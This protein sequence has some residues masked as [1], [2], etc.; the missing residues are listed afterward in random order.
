MG[1][2]HRQV[3][4]PAARAVPARGGDALRQ[5]IDSMSNEE[6][7]RLLRAPAGELRERLPGDN[8]RAREIERAVAELDD[9]EIAAAVC[10][11]GGHDLADLLDAFARGR[12]DRRDRPR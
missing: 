3:R 5:R 6:Y 4:P 11:L 10:D 12:R 1:D 2:D 8:A 9:A 7:Q